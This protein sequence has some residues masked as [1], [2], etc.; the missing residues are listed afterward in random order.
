LTTRN[1]IFSSAGPYLRGKG[2]GRYMPVD[3][4]SQGRENILAKLILK[5][6]YLMKK[7]NKTI[8]NIK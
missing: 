7:K 8:K 4:K 1:P 6:M 5:M 3:V 2:T